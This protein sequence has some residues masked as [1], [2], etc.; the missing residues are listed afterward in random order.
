MT[1]EKNF[2]PLR[3][4]L[5]YVLFGFLWIL[6]SDRALE[7][8]TAP[9]SPA[10]L[11]IQT[12]KGWLFVLISAGLIYFMLKIDIKSLATS[13]ERYRAIFNSSLDPIMLTSP[14]GEI[15]AV[16]PAGCRLFERTEEEIKQ[17]GRSGIVDASDP[18]LAVGLE[19]R[20]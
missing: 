6:L 5:R 2:T 13:E 11:W 7:L 19:E 20:N 12:A 17:I 4:A 15:L 10:H 1:I 16:N 3:T 8:F 14:N 18:R 9:G